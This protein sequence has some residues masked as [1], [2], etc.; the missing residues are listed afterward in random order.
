MTYSV[1]IPLQ[2]TIEI[3]ID[4]T[5]PMSFAEILSQI[6]EIDLREAALHLPIE[7]INSSFIKAVA[8]RSLKVKAVG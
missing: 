4:G 8:R 3:E 7:D 1:S 5:N 2:T 6:T